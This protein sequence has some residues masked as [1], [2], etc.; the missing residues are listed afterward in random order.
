[1]NPI[2]VEYTKRFQKPD[3]SPQLELPKFFTQLDLDNYFEFLPYL[4]NIQAFCSRLLLAKILDQRICIYSDYDTDAITATATMYFGLLELGFNKDKLDFYAPD[5]FT[6]GYGMNTEATERL[7]KEF[8]LIV[9]VDCGI[10]SV[11]E[12]E[13]VKGTNCDL[14]ITDHHHLHAET[15]DCVG[16]LNP[17]LGEYHNNNPKNLNTFLT[18]TGSWK[19]SLPQYLTLLV[20][21]LDEEQKIKLLEFYQKTTREP[22]EFTTNSNKFMSA[23][24]TGVGVAW[25]C[26]VWLGYFLE[27]IEN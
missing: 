3:I 12:A 25:F 18:K 14:I 7:A 27:I 23:S 19:K 4:N 16:V 6:E 15:P 8:D 17:R 11:N 26:V 13:I 21:N 22:T 2:L 20:E 24:V 9:S 1:M 10:N 5:R